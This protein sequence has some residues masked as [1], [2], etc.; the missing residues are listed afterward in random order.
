MFPI[1]GKGQGGSLFSCPFPEIVMVHLCLGA[2]TW[3]VFWFA[4]VLTPHWSPYKC[5]NGIKHLRSTILGIGTLRNVLYSFFS[6]HIFLFC[7]VYISD[8]S[9]ISCILGPALYCSGLLATAGH[10][11]RSAVYVFC[12]RSPLQKSFIVKKNK[13][14]Q[15]GFKR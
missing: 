7:C 8:K 13:K 3:T 11:R 9:L 2:R 12:T 6:C 14:K 10:A 1:T 15:C 5:C 4:F